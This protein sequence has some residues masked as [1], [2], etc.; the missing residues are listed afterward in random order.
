ML[1]STQLTPTGGLPA[2][3]ENK[4]IRFRQDP[5][6]P[7]GISRRALPMV[8]QGTL[9]QGVAVSEVRP[10]Q[11]YPVKVG[12]SM[13]RQFLSTCK[14][15][16]SITMSRKMG[17]SNRAPPNVSA[18][19]NGPAQFNLSQNMGTMSPYKPKVIT[20]TKRE[21][22]EKADK[23]FK[24]SM[25]KNE[26][27]SDWLVKHGKTD[28]KIK[29]TRGVG[30]LVTNTGYGGKKKIRKKAK[31]RMVKKLGQCILCAWVNT[32]GTDLLASRP[33]NRTLT[34]T[35]PTFLLRRSLLR[36]R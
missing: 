34:K 23:L 4:G 14:S 21:M 28:L 7:D 35:T 16:G 10:Y 2:Y 5:E 19:A 12:S 26:S 30:K 8:D 18:D 29:K 6:L 9:K 24:L 1:N 32:K 15:A 31:V 20:L 3:R 17:E 33:P 13:G 36:R 22:R 25:P 27:I 11:Q